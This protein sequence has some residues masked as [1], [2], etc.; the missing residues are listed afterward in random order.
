[1]LGPDSVQFLVTQLDFNLPDVTFPCSTNL[2]NARTKRAENS[3]NSWISAPFSGRYRLASARN[4]K[5]KHF[6]LY[7]GGVLLLVAIY[8]INAI[9]AFKF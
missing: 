4:L 8:G 1:M 6:P 5:A 3:L 2:F 9:Y 7:F